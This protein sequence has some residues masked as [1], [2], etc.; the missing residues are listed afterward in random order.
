L[1]QMNK[2]WI[3]L[4]LSA[5]IMVGATTSVYSSSPAGA[6]EAAPEQAAQQL[7]R[8][9]DSW[10]GQLAKEEGF[11]AWEG[12]AWRKYPLG[13]GQHGWVV[14]VTAADGEELGYL[15]VSANQG[16]AGYSLMEYGT[17]GLPLFSPA[18][19]DRALESEQ[20]QEEGVTFTDQASIERWYIGGAQALWKVTE[21]GV[22]RYADAKSGVWLPI[23]EADAPLDPP[24][25]PLSRTP[26]HFPEPRHILL[27]PADPYESIAWLDA[28]VANIRDW[29]SFLR[30]LQAS[31]GEGIYA[32][33]GF[34]GAALTPMGVAGFHWW[35]SGSY[36]AVEQEGL[37]YIPLE[38]LLTEGSFH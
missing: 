2:K 6:E 18:T 23:D 28:P 29:T 8:Q 13:P 10:I 16:E 7:A 3:T 17:G 22:T 1:L 37:R 12:A 30:W 9:I 31:N 5:L 19:L 26:E 27:Q 21:A 4:M 36:V 38:R 11:S 25:Q 32:S 14:I 24:L 35:A 34:G 15:V 33:Q 20:L